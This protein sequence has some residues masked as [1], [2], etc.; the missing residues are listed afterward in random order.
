MSGTERLTTDELTDAILQ[1]IDESATCD[2]PVNSL[3]MAE[4]VNQDHQRVVGVVSSLQT[5]DNL[6][7]TEVRS[8]RVLD[9][10]P[11]GRHFVEHGSHEARVFAAVPPVAGIGQQELIARIKDQADGVDADV[12]LSKALAAK[13]LQMD[14]QT[15][16][17]T[18]KVS[19]VSDN[20]SLLLSEIGDMSLK[21]DLSEKQKGELKKRKLVT[22]NTVKSFDVWKGSAFTV[23]PQK[24]ESEL[25][26]EMLASG[27][28]NKLQFKE[29]NFQAQGAVPE[30]G[31]L[32]PLLKVRTELRQIFLELGFSEMRTDQWVES[33]FWNFDS[34]FQ[35]QQH[36]ARDAHDTF[37]VSD[38]AL[39]AVQRI[40]P[41]DY[42]DRVQCVHSS[43]GYGSLGYESEWLVHEAQKNIL[44]THTT[45][46]SA[47]L[48]FSLAHEYE[49][50][51]QAA[52]KEGKE[53]PPFTGIKCFSID[54][55]FRN[56]TLDATHLAEFH[57]MEGV[58]A[59]ADLSLADLMA[60]IRAFFSKM[61]LQDVQFKAAFNPYT[62]P[63]MEIFAFHP[64]LQKWVEIGNSGIFRPEMLR[65]MRLPDH[66]SVIAFGLSVERP[67]MIKYGINNIRDLVG[68][69]VDLRLVHNNPLCLF[70]N[71]SVLDQ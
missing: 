17:V 31:H 41:A 9:L 48:L 21:S 68:H 36:P 28:W 45:A 7:R 18:R 55:V 19:E 10:T 32:H 51:V 47:R 63:S 35:P 40:A 37:F 1:L 44:R 59:D 42:V 67:T 60:V 58:V 50:Q 22:E 30:A 6:I 71:A 16:L 14:K 53:R 43:G 8:S 70:T 20:V 34:L 54:R 12:G 49:Q 66:V 65:P 64:G 13:W 61:G 69:R 15:K 38:P 27:D 56:E 62:E 4:R 57:Q 46:C 39:S 33:S 25:T 52:A 2:Q 29:Y 24:L 11:E 3:D 5:R 26:A 23:K